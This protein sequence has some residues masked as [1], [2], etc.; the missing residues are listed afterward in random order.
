MLVTSQSFA[1]FGECIALGTSTAAQQPMEKAPARTGSGGQIGLKPRP[2]PVEVFVRMFYTAGS[3]L[4]R[5]KLM[6]QT[7]VQIVSGVLA[8]ILIGIV[9]LRRKSRKKKAEEDDF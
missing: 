9:V 2:A 5:G 8:V 6:T 4:T 1:G 3:P 7:T